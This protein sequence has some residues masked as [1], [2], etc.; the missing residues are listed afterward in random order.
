M[1]VETAATLAEELRS[2]LPPE[3]VLTDA[4]TIAQFSED[5]TE[6]PGHAPDVVVR[7]R[8][9]KDVREV[10]LLA[11]RRRVPVVPVVANLNVGGLAIPERGGIVVDLSGMNR[12]LEVNE[13]DQYMLIE[14][15]VSW[16]DVRKLLDEKHPTL[17]FAYSF[18]PPHT[19]V[20]CN[21]LMD[22][23][24][25]LS[26]KHGST[27]HWVNG[28][29]AVLPTGE[30]VR[31]GSGSVGKTWCS[32]SPFPDLTGLFINFQGT[33]G[34][35]TKMA[36][37]L[38]PRYRLRKRAFV[39]GYDVDGSFALAKRLTREDVCDDIGGLSWPIAKLVFGEANPV[40]RRPEEPV[41]ILYLD[42]S[43]D[44]ERGMRHK[45]DVVDAAIAEVR[46]GGAKLGDPLDVLDLVKVEPRFEKFAD[47]PAR[48]DFLMD[49]PGGG[50]TWVGTYGP[51]SRWEEGI[52][53]GMAIMEERG[54]PP[55]VVTRPMLGGHF[56]VLRFI[57]LFDKKDPASVKR[58]AEVNQALADAVIELGFFPYKTP[59]WVLA[60]HRDKI[61]PG[62]LGLLDRVRR[63]LDPNGVLNPG[64]W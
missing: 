21:C 52:K 33:T 34:I 37:Q 63:A 12:I 64:K 35:V 54:W 55:I 26:L 58:V 59:G 50:I 62:F 18:S 28:L 4:A 14:P 51:V 47:L 44:D 45:L 8:D 2:L 10:V 13:A 56:G 38:W 5:V 19:S 32:N 20:L 46:R 1:P 31:T 25:N 3:N 49:H 43:D 16:G 11:N 24:V 53:R 39:M 27:S 36:V 57:E 17:R 61:D 30:V 48:L 42:I 60:R 23:L 40:H 41:F 22:G 6:V 9:T 15:G 29:E 7:V